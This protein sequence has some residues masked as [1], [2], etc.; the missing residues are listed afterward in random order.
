MAFGSAELSSHGSLA[1][2]SIAGLLDDALR[3][4]APGRR[5]LRAAGRTVTPLYHQVYLVLA[6][7]IRDG[8]LDP[9]QPLPGEPQLR[10]EEINAF[11]RKYAR[12]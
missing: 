11:L 4:S 2:R 10:I 8:L 7:R 12:R 3:S 6:Q 9:A 5:R 1:P